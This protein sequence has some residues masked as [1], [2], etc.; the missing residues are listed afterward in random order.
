M[1]VRFLIIHPDSTQSNISKSLGKHQSTIS[2]HIKNLLKKE[3]IESKS[4]GRQLTYQ[5]KNENFI[6]RLFQNY[7][8]IRE[9]QNEQGD[10][11][12]IYYYPM[13][14]SLLNVVEEIFTFPFCAGFSPWISEKK[15]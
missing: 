10:P 1:I 14:D 11:I 8:S 5:V 4:Y 3:I 6:L 9:K 7:F 13:M 12:G 2:Y 15:K